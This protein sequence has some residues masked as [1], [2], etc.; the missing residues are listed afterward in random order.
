MQMTDS[1]NMKKEIP[2][3]CFCDSVHGVALIHKQL[4]I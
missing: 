1:D 4:E 3:C 2:Y